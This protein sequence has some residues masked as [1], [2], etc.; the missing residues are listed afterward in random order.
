MDYAR[1]EKATITRA[2]NIIS[3]RLT[4]AGGAMSNPTMVRDYLHLFYGKLDPGREHFSVMYLNAQH[5]LITCEVM[6]S[7]TIDG[8][9]VYPRVVAR[10]ALELG[11]CAVIL[12]HNHPS[13][14]TQPSNADKQ[15]TFKLRDALALFEIRM[16]DHI[17]IGGREALSFAETGTL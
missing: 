2:L 8:A 9:A 4:V 12:A 13:G 1:H 3:E 10:R 17:I 5:R 16:L 11:A 14:S 15:I 6:F 7:G